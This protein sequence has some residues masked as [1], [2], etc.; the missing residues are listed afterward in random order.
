MADDKK[1]C[2]DERTLLFGT[3]ANGDRWIDFSVKLTASEGEIVLGDTKEGTFGVRV[4]DSLR[5]TARPPGRIVNSRGQVNNDAWG[6][7]AEWV[8]NSATLAGE[9]VGIAILSHPTNLRPAC[10]WHAR[11]YGLLSANPFGEREFLAEA[12]RLRGPDEPEQGQR[13]IAP[14]TSLTLRYRVLLHRGDAE[15]AGVA[16]AFREF[17]ASR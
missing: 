1:T 7:P 8:D 12:R 14:G 9:V 16:E 6:M 17:A 10:R 13:A 2:E 5:V 11:D 4:A 3:R 15:A